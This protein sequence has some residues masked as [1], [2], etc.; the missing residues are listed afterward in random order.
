MSRGQFRLTEIERNIKYL[1]DQC[2]SR[3]VF[4]LVV[5]GDIFHNANPNDEELRTFSRIISYAV[6]CGIRIRFI[7]GDHDTNGLH[8]SLESVHTIISKYKEDHVRIV[9]GRYYKESHVHHGL[10]IHFLPWNKK[11]QEQIKLINNKLEDGNKDY[12]FNILVSHVDIS[13]VRLPSG[14]KAKNTG[15]TFHHLRGFDLSLL[16][17]YH[18][19]I[20]VNKMFY[21]GSVIRI[22]WSERNESKSFFI[23]DTDSGVSETVELPDIRMIDLDIDEKELANLCNTSLKKINGLSLQD[24]VISMNLVSKNKHPKQLPVFRELL[25]KNGVRD[26]KITIRLLDE[27]N[28]KIQN[29]K[30][31]GIKLEAYWRQFCESKKASTEYIEHGLNIMSKF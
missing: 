30:K 2:Y 29:I 23:H 8:H 19:R 27:K 21:A 28:K 31:S 26:F 18:D 9:H 10:T 11:V 12:R 13:G 20:E 5:C 7:T 16:G 25:N 17:D 24:S 22:S 14:Y 6:D 4:Y 1:L 3:K 15:I